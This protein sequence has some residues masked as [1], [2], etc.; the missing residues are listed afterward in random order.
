MHNLFTKIVSGGQTGADRAGLDFSFMHNIPHGGWCPKGRKAE[1]GEISSK[2]SLIES[3]SEDY[4]Q[5]NEWN[6]RDSDGTIIFTMSK[7]L[8]GGSLKAA[9][10]ASRHGKPML[11][12]YP[13]MMKQLGVGLVRF[14]EGQEI[15]VLNIAGSRASKEPEVYQFT[16]NLLASAFV[17]QL[18]TGKWL[19]G[20]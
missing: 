6:A 4:D 8:I 17:P 20:A 15:R 16:F 19:R 7:Q 1:D 12:V 13:G 14:V 11:H 10:F 3:P 2:Y 18:V 9:E 5:R